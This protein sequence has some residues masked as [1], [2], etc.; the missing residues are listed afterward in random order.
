MLKRLSE[1]KASG[2]DLEAELT[3]LLEKKPVANSWRE[4]VTRFQGELTHSWG[5]NVRY[6]MTLQT[7]SD[8]DQSSIHAAVLD[9]SRL[10]LLLN[11][12]RQKRQSSSST[13]AVFQTRTSDHSSVVHMATE[14]LY[15]AIRCENKSCF[16]SS[17]AKV[18]G[19]LCERRGVLPS[20][21]DM[22]LRLYASAVQNSV[23]SIFSRLHRSLEDVRPHGALSDPQ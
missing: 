7:Q 23:H 22:Q 8:A 14:R 10:Y 4:G 13:I 20:D 11:A 1:V 21:V 9:P 18:V 2:R 3:G 12:E 5:Q 6:L 16:Q 15:S 17:L 19:R